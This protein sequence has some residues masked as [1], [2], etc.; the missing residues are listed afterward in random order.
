VNI[1][2]AL[3]WQVSL[4]YG[5]NAESDA[6]TSV[7]HHPDLKSQQVTSKLDV[8]SSSLVSRSTQSF[9][10]RFDLLLERPHDVTR[11]LFGTGLASELS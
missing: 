1:R 3:Q 2:S 8:A 7:F 5:Q 9:P 6:P 11:T 4:G 10:G